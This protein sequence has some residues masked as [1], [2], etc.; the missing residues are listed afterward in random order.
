MANVLGLRNV[1]FEVAD[2]QA[3]VD[4]LAAD[5]SGLVSGIGQHE[6]IWPHW[7]TSAGPKGWFLAGGT[8][9]RTFVRGTTA[10][11]LNAVA[12]CGLPPR[13]EHGC[14]DECRARRCS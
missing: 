4:G 1:C 13:L 5:G 6:G 3:T 9:H 12:P 8:D 10:Q 14:Q 2:M 7:P 11:G